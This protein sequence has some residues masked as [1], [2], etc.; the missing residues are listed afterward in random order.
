[1]NRMTRCRCVLI[2]VLCAASAGCR[3]AAPAAGT[4]TAEVKPVQLVPGHTQ[5]VELTVHYTLP[6]KP[7]TP[8]LVRYR[9]QLA[10]PQGW[11]AD[12]GAWA[13]GQTVQTTDIGFRDTRKVALT[14]PGDAAPGEHVVKLTVTPDAGQPHTL[15]LK[16]QVDAK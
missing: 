1:M 16:V 11:S 6:A 3:G 4:F 9:A 12:L 13:H 15:D 7:A 14:V 2:G 8:T 10:A 5:E